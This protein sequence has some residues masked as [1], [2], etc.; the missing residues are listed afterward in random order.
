MSRVQELRTA[1]VR[2]FAPACGAV[3]AASVLTIA[4]AAPQPFTGWTLVLAV[5]EVVTM[6]AGYGVTLLALR[7]R[8]PRGVLER[9][10]RH[11][12]AG[13]TSVLVLGLLSVLL[14]GPLVTA[15]VFLGMAAGALT[16]LAFW[17][18]ATLWHGAGPAD[19]T[20]PV[21]LEAIDE[22]SGLPDTPAQQER[23]P[24]NSD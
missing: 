10:R 5:V 1:V 12:I 16:A 6:S 20:D 19:R 8:L 7:H 18:P 21:L 17:L 23:A 4:M 14:Q 2:R 22:L 24:S 11:A 13:G 3:L 9:G 15:T